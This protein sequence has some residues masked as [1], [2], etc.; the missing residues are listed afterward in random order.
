MNTHWFEKFCV[1]LEEFCAD[2]NLR[3]KRWR[4]VHSRPAEPPVVRQVSG[5]SYY[6]DPDDEMGC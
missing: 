1:Q 6:Y 2:L 3:F 4:A 5:L